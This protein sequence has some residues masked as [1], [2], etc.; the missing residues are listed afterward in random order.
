MKRSLLNLANSTIKTTTIS[1]LLAVAAVSQLISNDDRIP[2]RSGNFMGNG[3]L[4]IWKANA[5]SEE[6]NLIPVP[7]IILDTNTF[8]GIHGF[9]NRIFKTTDAGATWRE[10]YALPIMD[11]DDEEVADQFLSIAAPTPSRMLFTAGEGR[12]AVTHDGG[13]SFTTID[14]NDFGIYQPRINN[15][16]ML[17]SNRGVVGEILDGLVWHTTDG[18]LSWQSLKINKQAIPGNT[19]GFGVKNLI[20]LNDSTIAVHL[21]KSKNGMM[22]Q[23]RLSG[24]IVSVNEVPHISLDFGWICQY[25]GDTLIAP[26]A[27]RVGHGGPG[28]PIKDEI[29]R[30]YDGGKNWHFL[31]KDTTTGGGGEITFS[32]Y[33]KNIGVQRFSYLNFTL[34]SGNTWFRDTTLYGPHT[35]KERGGFLISHFFEDGRFLTAY[36]TY[37]GI[38][39]L[40]I[41]PKPVLYD[42]P[43]SAEDPI[44]ESD[45]TVMPNPADGTATV[46]GVGN[47]TFIIYNQRGEAV[48]VISTEGES[49]TINTSKYPSGTYFG[50]SQSPKNKTKKFSFIVVR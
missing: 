6:R 20:Y 5:A 2:I 34:D 50:I 10:L 1:V 42:N 29:V 7:K 44:E 9:P 40:L 18:G 21:Q 39:Y 35:K 31:V 43:T 47:D 38:W 26:L 12:I 41:D 19:G 46:R 24:E 33:K 37:E 23:F 17:D 25:S 3:T 36:F 8:I 48:D 45:I 30:S 14:F 27:N 13:E 49:H 11:I 4:K 15:I 28:A 16:S 22:V 32:P